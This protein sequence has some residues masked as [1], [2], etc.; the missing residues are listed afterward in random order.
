MPEWPLTPEQRHAV[1]RFLSGEDLVIEAGA[2]TGK[3]ATLVALA[4]A[5]APRKGVYLAFNRGLTEDAA[6][7]LPANIEART[8]H[9]HAYRAVLGNNK[10]L[11]GRLRGGKRLS[12][13]AEAKFLRVD[14]LDVTGP[15]GHKR[16]AAGFMAGY[17]MDGVRRFCQ[18]A[19]AEPLAKHLPTIAILDDDGKRGPNNWKCAEAHV[20]ALKRAWR[21]LTADDGVLRFSHDHYLKMFQL[22]S[23]ALPGDFVLFDEAQDASPVIQSIVLGQRAHG[24]QVVAVGDSAQAIYGFTGAVNAMAALRENGD[25]ETAFLTKSFRFGPAVAG[26]ANALLD[27]LDEGDLRLVGHD[28]VQSTVG[29]VADPDCILTRTNARAVATAIELM[30][31]GKTVSIAKSL[32]D[33]VISFAKAAEQLKE[34]GWTGHPELAPFSTWDEVQ[35]FVDDDL[36]G[37]ELGL[38]VRLVDQFGADAIIGELSRTVSESLADVTLSTAH[39]SKG[40]EWATVRIAGDFPQ[41]DEG[42]K[43]PQL[44]PEELRLLYVAAT[45]AMGRL[46]L[47]EVAWINTLMA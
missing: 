28:P 14:A 37:H 38:M 11:Q 23:P 39:T 36:A 29:P 10:A 35:R 8:V 34:S 43:I 7:R 31:D 32:K 16:L 44:A 21:D 1:D 33:S 22:A 13:T 3:T 4:E 46:D 24:K 45:R 26:V 40:R 41:P 15:L 17:V 5:C 18:S 20:P 25:A 9:S 42:E 2:G 19:D 12:R 30:A 47:T 27:Q 6:K